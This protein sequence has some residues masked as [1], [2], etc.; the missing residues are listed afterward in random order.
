MRGLFGIIESNVTATLQHRNGTDFELPEGRYR[1]L[2]RA[3]RVATDP[4][5]AASYDSWIS[6]PFTYRKGA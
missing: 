4:T 1:T 3:Q 2:V 5:L 6:E